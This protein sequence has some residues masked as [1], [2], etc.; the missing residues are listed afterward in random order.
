M[1]REPESVNEAELHAYVDGQLD[2]D[3]R[4][5]VERYLDAHPDRAREVASW[6]RQNDALRAL[7]GRVAEETPPERLRISGRTAHRD[8]ITGW[9]AIAAASVLLI[10]G[11]S[12]GWIGRD[13][14][15]PDAVYEASLVDAAI[16]AHAVYAVEVAHPVE[17]TAREEDHLVG[18]LSKRLGR[19]LSAPDLSRFDFQLV[20]GRLL[21]GTSGPA[22]QFMYENPQGHRI[23]VYATHVPSQQMAAF[24]FKSADDVQSFYWRDRDLSYAVV[25]DIE[26][27]ALKGLALQVYEQLS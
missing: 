18:W 23:T 24:Q 11:G 4:A 2:A 14:T 27:D 8:A 20:G 25:G 1:T 15:A 21:P 22:A 3:R 9:K 17:V 12:L 7:Y 16:A 13:L 26:R 10:A 6:E 5:V 19:K